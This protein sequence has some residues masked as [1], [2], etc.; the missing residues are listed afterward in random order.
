MDSDAPN[1][2]I[3]AQTSQPSGM[4][5]ASSNI[6]HLTNPVSTHAWGQGVGYVT[7]Q[8][9]QAVSIPSSSVGYFPISGQASLL[10]FYAGSTILTPQPIPTQSNT[11][12]AK[13]QI[14]TGSFDY[15]Q[16]ETEEDPFD[17][18]E[19]KT[20]NVM[21]E[22]NKVLQSAQSSSSTTATPNVSTVHSSQM[23]GGKE[24]NNVPVKSDGN[25]IPHGNNNLNNNE[26]TRTA[27]TTKDPNIGTTQAVSVPKEGQIA[28][29][30]NMNV[31][32]FSAKHNS[33][34]ISL[35]D[36]KLT[37]SHVNGYIASKVND[38]SISDKTPGG[39]YRSIKDVD[40]PELD[41]PAAEASVEMNKSGVS[42][43]SNSVITPVQKAQLS[44]TNS[45]P[46]NSI[47][48]NVGYS[49]SILSQP[50]HQ[51]YNVQDITYIPSQNKDVTLNSLEKHSNY[52]TDFEKM[53]GAR[54]F[55]GQLTDFQSP[56]GYPEFRT[57]SHSRGS[58]PT[59]LKS[60]LRS[61][62][63][64]PDLSAL[65]DNDKATGYT[66][67]RTPPASRS[68]TPVEMLSS[69]PPSNQV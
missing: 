21:D 62:K 4:F 45:Y 69:T 56:S 37:G 61:A 26:Q 44:H 58:S 51:V 9:D 43:K 3:P 48:G 66:S 63:S 30:N 57:R 13:R 38:L 5:S 49:H 39:V 19:L 17:N 41:S 14:S 53:Y 28:F 1:G 25:N 46:V 32:S 8:Q 35:D 29:A 68:R 54:R 27:D 31:V 18:L 20:L 67:S 65:C 52:M 33:G 59:P 16:F 23:S 6:N 15:A 50:V 22:L 36:K 12:D 7:Q 60:K 40:Y 34:S 47:T 2:F 10:P 42:F 55:N 64:V 24:S 11:A